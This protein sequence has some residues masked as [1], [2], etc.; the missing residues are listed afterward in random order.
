[1]RLNVRKVPDSWDA[2][3]ISLLQ[4]RFRTV[5]RPA[6]AGELNALELRPFNLS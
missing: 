1:M 6:R 3:E 5:E 4:A 2:G